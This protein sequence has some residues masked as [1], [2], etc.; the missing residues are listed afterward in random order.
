MFAK[1]PAFITR[2]LAAHS[3][4]FGQDEGGALIIFGLVLF[5]LMCMIGGF[6]V[7][8]MRFEKTR[9]A[10]QN[11]L[12]RC[13]LNAA[14]LT[15]RLDPEGVV[16][17]CVEK[18]GFGDELE[19]VTVTTGLNFRDVTSRGVAPTDPFFLHLMGID[20]FDAGA[21]S[22]AVQRIDNIEISLVLDVSGSMRGAKIQ[23]LREAAQEFVSTVLSNDTQNRVSIS[24]VPYN[25]QVNLGQTLRAKYNATK[26]HGVPNSN[27]LE[28]QP[29]VYD[30]PGISRTLPI[31][32]MAHA[33][34]YYGTST[35]NAAVSPLSA[36]A[37]PRF[38]QVYCRTTPANVVRL[39]SRDIATLQANLGAL[40]AN[41]NTSI[42]L[43]MKW[44]LA[45]LDPGARP[46]F[47]E[48]AEDGLIPAEMA[49]R[50]FNYRDPE[51]TKIIVLMTDGEHVRHPRVTDGFKRGASN[52]FR[53]DGDG[54]YSV[55]ILTGRPAAA[56]TNEYWVP[57]LG[58]WQAT[59]WVPA[60]GVQTVVE[61][62][63]TQIWANLKLSYVA[64]QFYG[65]AL[66]TTGTERNAAY[67]AKVNEMVANYALENTMN[68]QLQTSCTQAE[69][70]GVIVYGIAFEAPTNGQFQ[71]SQCSTANGADGHYFNA[72]DEEALA[73]AFNTISS[74]ITQLKLTQ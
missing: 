5:L 70:N 35:V 61:Q 41:G 2:K 30:T 48:F 4:R 39:P 43:G 53:A 21:S 37:L 65:R 54:N 34:Y 51:A 9:T 42:T 44:G 73:R 58:T 33:D 49:A 23:A 72:A 55:R 50:P 52:I 27:C 45:L 17:D 16:R 56:G 6:A 25:A 31:P 69:A 59:P 28:L 22:G 1:T 38:D 63:W 7:D 47:A 10:L 3:R 68:D 26:Q 19:N 18:G 66:G 14:S 60:S 62:D 32:M 40:E 57:H 29:E 20:S 24:I 71:I 74:N 46:M 13:T 8:L 15:Q 67:N 12:D 64:W 11:T 36:S